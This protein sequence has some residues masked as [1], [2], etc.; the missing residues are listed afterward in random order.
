MAAAA[1]CLTLSETWPSALAAAALFG[2][3]FGCYIAVDQALITQVLP[4]ATERAK[5]LGVINIANVG[6]TA[7]GTAIAAPVVALGGYPSL[8]VLTA[9]ALV[10]GGIFVLK[11][12]SVR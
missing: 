4:A 1:I 6:S 8:Y 2:I 10:L 9:V 12:K 3:G 5:D 7:V 11:I